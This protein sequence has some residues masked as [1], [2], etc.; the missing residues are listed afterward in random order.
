MFPAR[1]YTRLRDIHLARTAGSLAFTTLLAIVPLTAVAVAFVARFPIFERALGAFEAFL[2]RHFLP[3]SAAPL[4]HEHLLAFAAQAARLTGI[5]LPLV[6]V[7]AGMAMYTVEREINAI[8]GIRQGRSLVRRILVY[9]LCMTVGP[10]LVGTSI[11]LTTWAIA[12]SFGAVPFGGGLDRRAAAMLPFVFSAVGLTLLYRYVPARRV[13]A[14]PA[15]AGGVLAALALEAA[16][17]LFA[18][19]LK[20]VPTWRLV[21]GALSALPIFMV[22][23]YVA[24]IVVLAGAAVTAT[25]AEGARRR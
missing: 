5:A 15:L 2:T 24:W 1:V 7:T 19:Y 22:W 20:Q 13:R 25:L 12:H 3:P 11:S 16:K 8:W 17:Y 18:L 14:G 4:V 21:Y 6:V 9:A 10:V 23:I